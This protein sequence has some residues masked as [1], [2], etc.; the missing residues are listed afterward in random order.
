MGCKETKW[1]KNKKLH[2]LLDLYP[3]LDD[4]HVDNYN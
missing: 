1:R 3:S 2:L 4:V